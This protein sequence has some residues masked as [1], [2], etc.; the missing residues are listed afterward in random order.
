M[1]D[2]NESCSAISPA[3]CMF[4]GVV[5]NRIFVVD[6]VCAMEYGHTLNAIKYFRD[7][8]ANY[9]NDAVS[10]AS[11]HL[12]GTTKEDGIERFFEFQYGFGLKIDR[13]DGERSA[14]NAHFLGQSPEG[15][16]TTDFLELI[17]RHNIGSD[18]AIMF[19][20]VDYYSLLGIVAVLDTR[21]PHTLP[22]L[23]I[24]FIGVLENAALGLTGEAAFEKCIAVLNAYVQQGRRVSV[25]AETPKYAQRL[26]ER[27]ICPVITV[28][29]FSPEV[30]PLPAPE[31]SD[32]TTFLAGGSARSDKGFFNLVEII[33]KANAR[34][35]AENLH[36]IVQSLPD[37][38]VAENEVY[39]RALLSQP[40]VT[41]MAGQVSYDEIIE[42]F[43]ASH[44]AL[45]PYDT[46]TYAW[47]G[48]AML[49]E[50]MMFERLVIA[51]AGTGFA[52]QARF[53]NAGELVETIDDFAEAI[54]YLSR[55]PHRHLHAR[56]AQARTHYMEDVKTACDQWLRGTE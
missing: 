1:P 19:P 49:M 54:S 51:Q 40:N 24:R 9:C 22:L 32:R 7:M 42:A 5:M 41:L 15:R 12:P 17:Q 3:A 21:A 23:Y 56:A 29:Y 31:K 45:M 2:T 44:V 30:V 50:A 43:A 38:Q 18:D 35:G 34:A 33:Q 47:R 8:A 13:R 10:V 16:S 48:S 55:V 4:S 26:R 11:Y 37:S 53:Y 46:A 25:C 39:I 52:D 14:F 27:L 36:F 6:P 20:G 28:P